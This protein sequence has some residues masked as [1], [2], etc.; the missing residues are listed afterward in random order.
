MTELMYQSMFINLYIGVTKYDNL[1]FP[2]DFL[3]TYI[4]EQDNG[5][6]SYHSKQNEITYKGILIETLGI[7]W[8]DIYL[9]FTPDALKLLDGSYYS[10]KTEQRDKLIDQIIL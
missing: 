5:D 7:K 9:K 8:N 1:E 2:H 4:F 10:Y 6:G 3:E